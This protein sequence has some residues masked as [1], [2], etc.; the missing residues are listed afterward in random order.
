MHMKKKLFGSCMLRGIIGFSAPLLLPMSSDS[1]TPK[2]CLSATC[3]KHIKIQASKTLSLIRL[4][5]L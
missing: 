2:F 3:V 4:C 1:E 5:D